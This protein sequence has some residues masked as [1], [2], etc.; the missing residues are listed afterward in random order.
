MTAVYLLWYDAG[1]RYLENS[2][3]C[4][5]RAFRVLSCPSGM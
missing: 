5:H 4:M 3:Y 1:T 2:L